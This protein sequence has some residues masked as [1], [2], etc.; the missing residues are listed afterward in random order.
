MRTLSLWCCCVVSSLSLAQEAPFAFADFSWVPGNYGAAEKPLTWGPF[1][2]EVRVDSVYHF[3]FAN[4][5]DNTISGSSEVFRHGEVQVI[6]RACA[7][8]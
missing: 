1:S 4:P 5:V 7:P 3:S 2:G 8:L 6:S